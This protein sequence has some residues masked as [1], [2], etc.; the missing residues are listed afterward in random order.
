V[1]RQVTDA[2]LNL[3]FDSNVWA[4]LTYKG[5]RCLQ[6]PTDAWIIQEIIWET[7]PEVVV[8]TGFADGGSA[9]LW[10]D[11]LRCL[12]GRGGWYDVISV[13]N[14]PA[15]VDRYNN[16]SG[17]GRLVVGDSADPAVFAQVASLVNDRPTLVILDSCHDMDHVLKELDLYSRLVQPGHYLVVEDTVLNGRPV[18]AGRGPGPGEAV[19]LW[20]PVDTRSSGRTGRGSACS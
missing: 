1:S 6:L 20:L 5:V 14:D 13:D 11:S 12:A 15:C 8:E 18:M 10:W 7:R 3:F 16:L 19:D 2:F 9:M 4:T 17:A